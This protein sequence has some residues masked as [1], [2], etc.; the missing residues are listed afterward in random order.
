MLE[1]LIYMFVFKISLE[2]YC[3]SHKTH[4]SENNEWRNNRIVVA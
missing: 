2:S 1:K 3:D 4:L